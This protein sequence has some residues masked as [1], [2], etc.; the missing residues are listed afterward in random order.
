MRLIR[1]SQDIH[2]SRLF[3]EKKIKDAR[4]FI[5]DQKFEMSGKNSGEIEQDLSRYSVSNGLVRSLPNRPE[6]ELPGRR[7]ELSRRIPN[8]R[9]S[10][11][12]YF[13]NLKL[14]CDETMSFIIKFNIVYTWFYW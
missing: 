7:S 5:K 8:P 14:S 2:F 4:N 3:L 6:V 12:N 9:I 1:R 11:K 10:T 13:F